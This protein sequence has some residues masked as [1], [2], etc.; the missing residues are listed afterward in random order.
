M[1]RISKWKLTL[2]IAVFVFSALYLLPSVPGFYGKLYGYFGIWMQDRIAPPDVQSD[3]G[4][5][6]IRFVIPQDLPKGVN[7]V[8]ASDSIRDIVTRR[9]TALKIGEEVEK[10][11]ESNSDSQFSFDSVTFVDLYA[12]FGQVKT[13]TELEDIVSKLELGGEPPLLSQPPELPGGDDEGSIKFTITKADIPKGKS[14]NGSPFAVSTLTIHG[15]MFVAFPTILNQ[16]SS[17]SY[18]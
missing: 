16:L 12:R 14:I 3:D 2:I 15:F 18:D 17:H 11:E 5:E 8:E 1:Y 4:G 6:F 10:L 13:R 7:V 9:L